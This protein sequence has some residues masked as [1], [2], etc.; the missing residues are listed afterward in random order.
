MTEFTECDVLVVGAGLAGLACA[1]RLV[2]RGRD[3]IVLES[4]DRVG[5]RVTSDDVDGFIVDRGFQVL[6]PAY[7]SLAEVVPVGRLGLRPFPRAIAVRRTDGLSTLKDPT[8]DPTALAG[9]LSSGLVTLGSA[10]LGAFFAR[11]AAVDEPYRRAFD[12]ARFTGPLRDEVVEPFLAGVI[13]EDQGATSSRFVSWLLRLFAQGTPGVPARGMRA[14][15]ELLARGLDV[16]LNTPVTEVA[17]GTVRT[18]GGAFAARSV[19][20]A[21]G[22]GCAHLAPSASVE[23]HGTRTF[24]FACDAAPASDARIHVDGRRT[25]PVTT[26]CV[27]SLAAPSYAPDG[28]HLVPA[29]TLTERGVASEQDVRSH[30]TEI[31]GVPTDGWEVVAVHDLPHTVPAVRPPYDTGRRVERRDDRTLICGDLMG[32]ASTEGALASGLAAADAILA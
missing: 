16:R 11:A 18:D 3:V 8:R 2:D 26:T 14:L 9:D 12:V 7:P 17:S 19:V 31:Y 28:R 10:G 23:W 21:A 32:N 25:G 4:A 6:N 5:G 27:T 1:Q 13:C 30:L 15:P 20:L 29:L 24:W 22:P